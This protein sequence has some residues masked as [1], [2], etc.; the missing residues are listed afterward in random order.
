MEMKSVY[1]LILNCEK[2]LTDWD[3]LSFCAAGG[4]VYQI[5]R[6]DVPKVQC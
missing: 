4:E 5:L 3:L 6:T 1:W 2:A